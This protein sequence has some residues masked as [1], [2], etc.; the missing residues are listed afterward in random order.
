MN[1]SP[2]RSTSMPPV[3]SSVSRTIRS[4]SR[5]S[6]RACSSPSRST[7]GVELSISV[8]TTV[9]VPSGRPRSPCTRRRTRRVASVQRTGSPRWTVRIACAISSGRV[10]L[11]RKPAAPAASVGRTWSSSPKVESASTLTSGARSRSAAVASIPPTSGMTTSI[12]TTSGRSASTCSTAAWPFSASP[13]TSMSGR[14]S[15]KSRRPWRTTAWSSAMRTRIASVNLDLHR[16]RRP[17]PGRGRHRED[18]ADRLGPLA[19][20]DQAQSPPR[21]NTFGVEADAVVLHGHDQA[22]AGGAQPHVDV[23]GVAVLERVRRRL[24]RDAE[25]LAL[26][27]DAGRTPS[28]SVDLE[29]DLVPV[30]APE[31]VDVLLERDG[32][33][34]RRDVRR[35][36]LE[37]QR[38]H[39][40]HRR[41]DELADLH[42][43]L[44]GTLRIRLDEQCGRVGGE[45]DAEEGLVD[46][47]VELACEPVPLL[48]HRE[49]TAPLV[50]PRVVD[51]DCGMGGERLD[52]LEVGVAED[53]AARALLVGEIE[54][55]DHVALRSD[56]NAEERAHVRVL[57]GP[58]FEAFVLLDVREAVALGRLEHRAEQPM[59][60][61]KLADGV[62][63]L[64]RHSRR[65]EVREPALAVGNAD[66]RVARAGELAR[67]VGELLEHG[68]EA[69]LGRDR[70][71]DVADG[72]EGAAGE[73][74]GH[75]QND[76]SPAPADITRSWR[77]ARRS[78]RSTR[79]PRL[80]V[81]AL[82][83]EKPPVEKQQRAR[84][85]GFV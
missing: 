73:R 80:G 36:Q 16:N 82:V 4:C 32:K 1:L 10:S 13:T 19:H 8:K 34:V 5:K 37:D 53:R 28:R 62:V 3:R 9:T 25:D 51:R 6:S 27:I 78:C 14:T 35:A 59:L 79:T 38:A 22:L 72:A 65:D 49:L 12:T 52:Q 85:A 55:A 69:V 48:D 58:A 61:R 68:L 46:G 43:L 39:L 40:C 64:L 56:R 29:L 50:E 60:A 70:D 77:R 23:L 81:D 84:P 18:A 74:L 33:A 47:V 66:R 11:V 45:R 76:T 31:H 71:D 83:S 21:L 63:L 57:V 67:R 26:D 54:G 30:D 2:S 44:L 42:Q 41:A 7:S 17:G 75:A 20:R 15:R 24:L